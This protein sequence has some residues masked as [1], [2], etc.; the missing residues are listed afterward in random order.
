M[1]D[2]Q[3][4]VA[5][6]LSGGR[7]RLERVDAQGQRIPADL[8]VLAQEDTSWTDYA[9]R[10]ADLPLDLKWLV[11]A[12]EDPTW[13]AYKSLY[14][15]APLDLRYVA[16]LTRDHR[17]L[18]NAATW[19]YTPVQNRLQGIARR[20]PAVARPTMADATLKEFL[21]RVEKGIPSDLAPRRLR[22]V[23]TS[24]PT[25]CP[26]GLPGAP[27]REVRMQFKVED[28]ICDKQ[29][30]PR[31]AP[32]P[33]EVPTIKPQRVMPG[34]KLAKPTIAAP[35]P[36]K[37]PSK[38]EEA[39]AM[40]VKK[41]LELP[42][43]GEK[44]ALKKPLEA[45]QLPLSPPK[46]PAAVPPLEKKPVP[47]PVG[48]PLEA[49]KVEV[50]G[51][52]EMVPKEESVIAPPKKPLLPS[53][54]LPLMQPKPVP[55]PLMK[56]EIGAAETE[57]PFGAPKRPPLEGLPEPMTLVTPLMEES[58][59]PKLPITAKPKMVPAPPFPKVPKE[60]LEG[61]PEPTKLVSP[62]SKAAAVLPPVPKPP[63]GKLLKPSAPSVGGEPTE[64]AA[65]V[66]KEIE[67]GV[68]GLVKPKPVIPPT[69]EETEGAPPKPLLKKP[70]PPKLKKGI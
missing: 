31:P 4:A 33:P 57:E 35:P 38:E 3:A 20:D 55:K 37:L 65:S 10:W 58:A 50:P 15:R 34:E 48:P 29:L 1:T 19:G 52:K 41:V 25:H 44:P 21:E 59:K 69:T 32:P 36:P 11:T 66:I 63:L 42:K 9:D 68:G 70:P 14:L 47:A 26:M 56:K 27:P 53:P 39:K 40:L 30:A 8:G 49:K 16:V 23:C 7:E 28:I 46:P 67:S 2:A 61:L 51:P 18:H 5:T 54:K 45:P 60:S 13:M 22:E 64:A 24:C 12:T 62:A 17:W 43:V 6:A